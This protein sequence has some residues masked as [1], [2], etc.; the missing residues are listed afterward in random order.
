MSKKHVNTKSKKPSEKTTAW[1]DP[2]AKREQSKYE[3][4]IASRELILGVLEKLGIP[5]TLD[6]LL[7]EFALTHADDQEALRR[8]LRAMERD[9]Q[10]LRNRRGGYI[11]ASHDEFIT[12][13]VIGHPDGFGFL[14]PETGGDDLYLGAREMRGLLHGDKAM[15]RA[16]GVDHRG[17]IEAKVVEV[18]ERANT[19]I[20]GR[21][22]C[23]S[24]AYFVRPD[25]K[26]IAQD[27]LVPSEAISAAEDGQIVIVTLVEQPTKN[28][29]PIG[30]ISQVLGDHMAPGMEVTIAVNAHGLPH[31]WPADVEDQIKG[32]S[33]TVT[34]AEQKGRKDLRDIPLVTIDGE[35]S[36]DYD[37]AVYCEP[38]EGGGW[39]L[40]VAI[41]DVSHYVKPGTALDIEG[42]SR[43][44]SVYFPGEVI[45]MLPEVLSNGLCSLN[46][47]VDRLCMVCE[48]RIDEQ[49]EI[50]RVRFYEGLMFSH[51]R[52]TY[53]EVAEIVVNK[54]ADIR[55]KRE[56]LLPHL[57]N[58]YDMYHAM[59]AARKKRGAIDFETTEM[60]F[61]FDSNR[62][63]AAIV[64]LVRNDAHKIIE[65]CMIAAN[66]ATARYLHDN[67]MPALYRIH[68]GPNEQKLQDLKA[69][70]LEMGL[71]LP[72]GEN[73]ESQH[74]AELLQQIKG[75]PDHELI[76]TVL[77]RSLMRAVYSPETKGHFGLS[78]SDYAH[79]TSPIRRYPDLLV[80]RAIR[81]VLQRGD[82]SNYHYSN[83]DMVTLGEHCSMAERRADD[84]TRDASDWL[85]CEYMLERIGET[86]AGVVTGVTNFGLFIQLSELH[87]EGLVH[88]TNLDRDYY[89]FDGSAHRLIGERT[90]QIFQLSD[91][92]EVKVLSVN[93]EDRKIDFEMVSFKTTNAGLRKVR[94]GEKHRPK[95][96]KKK[97]SKKKFGKTKGKKAQTDKTL[98]LKKSGTAKGKSKKRK[99]TS[100][101]KTNTKKS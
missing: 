73:P 93:M 83:N 67:K 6:H 43:G 94:T 12:G 65:E 30:K 100:T 56:T 85:K 32:L 35:D 44:T 19:T 7:T 97:A 60:G 13:R 81:H 71:Y 5:L 89:V 41:A 55:K 3:K 80:H 58:L 2:H 50:S 96:A 20:V 40:L 37:D 45:P 29:Q 59:S 54:N 74:Y 88:I 39:K 49:G 28:N 27:V 26:R 16:M 90:G 25:N 34:K 66:V 75:R 23:E 9:G 84:A 10:V 24:G 8:R 91:N 61:E 77:L 52:L 98:S 62:R 72:G 51:A 1:K 101:K 22:H 99:K 53:T 31:T 92:V 47:E 70:L 69:F 36:R 14:A 78:L 64:P 76:Q 11:A 18:L 38:I 68:E 42:H 63:I 95:S 4:P 86:Y 17:R 15:V 79:F 21:F 33:K 82:A 87:I 46:P 57:E 48:M